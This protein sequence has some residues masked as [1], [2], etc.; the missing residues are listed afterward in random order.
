MDGCAGTI[1]IDQFEVHLTVWI[2]LRTVLCT[3]RREKSWT[4]AKGIVRIRKLNEREHFIFL[5]DAS[6]MMLL[7][8]SFLFYSE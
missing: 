5:R 2:S 4:A 8:R 3:V 7:D 6:Q 1:L